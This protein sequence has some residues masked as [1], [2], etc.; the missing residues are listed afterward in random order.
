MTKM[1][2]RWGAFHLFQCGHS[3]SNLT[4]EFTNLISPFASF[5]DPQMCGIAMVTCQAD[6]P[7]R[8]ASRR[9]T[10][11]AEVL[12]K[13][14][15][16]IEVSSFSRFRFGESKKKMLMRLMLRMD[17]DLD[18]GSTKDLK[19]LGG[20]ALR[21]TAKQTFHSRLHTS[22]FVAF[23]CHMVHIQKSPCLTA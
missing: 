22:L 16:Q 10:W 20:V 8:R 3:Q 23:C 5:V 21:N 6:A 12:K 2:W 13:T 11:W 15:P 19:K 18:F 7:E 17:S 4:E 9:M 14:R 1:D